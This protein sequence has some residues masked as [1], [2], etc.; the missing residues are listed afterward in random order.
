MLPALTLVV[1]CSLPKTLF[2]PDTAGDVNAGSGSRA[3]PPVLLVKSASVRAVQEVADAFSEGC[4][5]HVQQIYIGEG[6]TEVARARESFQSARVLVAVGQPAIELMVG[7]RA[8]VVYALA[9]DP[10]PGTIGTN[11]SAPPAQ[12]FRTLLA[13]RPRTRRI[14]AIASERGAQR[15]LH[16]KAAARSLGIELVELSAADSGAAI[17]ALRALF[18]PMAEEQEGVTAASPVDA[19]W[20]GA[21]PQLI[22]TQVLQFALQMQI[23]WQVPVIASTRQQVSFGALLAVDWPLEAVGKHL[24]W[25][26]NQLLDDPAHIGEVAREHPGGAPDAVINAQAARRFG[27]PVDMLRHMPGWKVIER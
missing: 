13:I 12:V 27:I 8:H 17:R 26:V 6:P 25:Q 24:A 10:P 18:V 15:L 21:D 5:V 9:P 1:L 22:D 2:G 23:Q 20:L 4:R 3:A 14:A 7:V 11:N 16:A 19:L